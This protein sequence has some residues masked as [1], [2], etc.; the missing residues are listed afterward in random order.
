MNLVLLG[1]PGAGKGTQAKRLV[2]KY[3]LVHLASGDILRA[4]RAA[5]TDLGRQVAGY[6]D[7]GELVPDELVT[8]VI[9][10]RIK[11]VISCQ[12]AG[13]FLLDGFPRTVNQSQDL[14]SALE[15][16][17]SR[18]D[19][20]LDLCTDRELT[21]SRLTGRRSCPAC[22]AVYHLSSIAPKVAET[23]DRC[24]GKLVHRSDDTEQVVQQRLEVYQQQTAPLEQYY[25]QRG[26][27]RQID[28]NLDIDQVSQQIEQVLVELA[29]T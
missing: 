6:M 5:S 3:N 25:Q 26:L 11:D 7:A 4:Q 1:P 24:G 13:G 23:C 8:Q 20:V 12:Q 16:A 28:G 22:G 19:A 9:L 2:D 14:G 21:I 10:D 18:I 15:E 27:L 29:G 17:R